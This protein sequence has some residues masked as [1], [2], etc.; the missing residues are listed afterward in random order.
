MDTFKA[1]SGKENFDVQ[2]NLGADIV[3]RPALNGGWVVMHR[4]PELGYEAEL[5]AAYS[6]TGEMLD[7][8][9]KMLTDPLVA[10]VS[11]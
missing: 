1:Y 2:K 4:A 11:A 10:S 5:T 9:A 7:G 3:L 6:G 8:L